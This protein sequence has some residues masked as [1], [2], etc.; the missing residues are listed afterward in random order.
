M[1][2]SFAGPCVST[3]TACSSSLVAA[4]LAHSGI[5]NSE[6]TAAVAA[7]VN[8]ILSPVTTVA[9]CQ[10]QALSPVGRCRSFDAAGDG[11]GRG[12]GIVAVLLAPSRPGQTAIA[13]VRSSAVNQDGQSSG[14]T[15]PN[16]P[17]QTKLVLNALR[18]GSLSPA[19]LRFVAVHGT[20]TPLGDP[21]EVGALGQAARGGGS[22]TAPL[23]LASVKSCYG[24]TEGAAGLTGLLMA[25][26]AAAQQAAPPVMH[27]RNVNSYV[28]AALGDWR[29][30]SQLSA[31]IPRQQQAAPQA[32]QLAG[33]SSFGM[34]GVNAHML[35]AAPTVQDLQAEPTGV[36]HKQLL[37]SQRMWPLA[38]AHPMLFSGLAVARQALFSCDLSQPALA[39]LWQQSVLGRT[40]LPA[41]A[42]L[43]LMAAAGCCLSD[44]AA[45]LAVAGAA[46]SA[47]MHCEH[48]AIVTCGMELVS[49][50]LQ[51]MAG[52]QVAVTALAV[53]ATAVANTATAVAMPASSMLG[54]LVATQ[55]A[56]VSGEQH[57]LASMAPLPFLKAHGYACHPS[58]AQTAISLSGG[59]AAAQAVLGCELYLPAS[60][61]SL[62]A[63]A[64]AA[65]TTAQLA[66]S[67]GAAVLQ[68]QGLV[69]KPLASLLPQ[70]IAAAPHSP[71]WQLAWQP[72]QF[73]APAQQASKHTLIISTQPWP[74]HSLCNHAAD[75]TVLP[76]A[77]IN[78]V[79]G[80]H[81]ASELSIASEAHLELLLCTLQPQQVLFVQP[82]GAPVDAA[83]ALATYR[84]VARSPAQLRLSLVTYD[85]QEVG[86]FVARFDAATGLLQGKRRR[87]K[88]CGV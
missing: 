43:E 33:T 9:I 8:A 6:S 23:A 80:S 66:S 52:G 42:A 21:I 87:Q 12:E 17:S 51:L 81:A 55:T 14:L 31:A 53:Q 19:L 5:L 86:S 28:E 29:K 65:S 40:T 13:V 59:A 3:D 69:A 38:P 50:A 24:H 45:G 79:W 46:F 48:G 4:H 57:S 88:A 27:L 72:V 84:A 58:F 35:V 70:R 64:A 7:G 25:A 22:S 39:Y 10:L 67:S 60:A 34:S 37:R 26:A 77:A 68:V 30:H 47:P 16:G 18:Q 73:A 44:A 15:A 54:S 49:G 83:A 11:Y 56:A 85:Q 71:A 36:A 74:L 1:L 32:A 63:A 61:G 76:L 75:A 62:A 41:A 2:R 78:A 82:P 20:G